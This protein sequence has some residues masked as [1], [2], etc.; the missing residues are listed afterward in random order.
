[1]LPL[2]TTTDDLTKVRQIL[3]V[4]KKDAEEGKVNDWVLKGA[5]E[6]YKQFCGP[7]KVAIQV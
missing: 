4:V 5:K 6:M 7:R 1:L 2:L 3:D